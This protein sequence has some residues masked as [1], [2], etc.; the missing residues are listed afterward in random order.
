M[1]KK[2]DVLIIGGGPGG[3]SAALYC[4]RA[5]LSTLVLEMLSAG[6]QMA[7]TPQVDNYPGFDDG[8]DGF[9][10]G[11]KMLAGAE[12]FGAET[13]FAE[14]TKLEWKGAEKI[15]H[16]SDGDFSARTVILA[17]GAGPKKLGLAEEEL[18]T[19]RGVAYCAAC[20]GMQYKGKTVAVAGGGNSAVADALTLSKLCK[21][22]YLV[23]RRDM[24]RADKV[25]L[26]AISAAGNIEIVWNARID[27]F[28]HHEKFEGLSITDTVTKKT[29]SLACDG[30][31][32]AVGRTPNTWLVRGAL[33]M[34]EQGYIAAD[35]T[36]CTSVG[37]VFA[38]GDIRAK[39]LRQIVTAVADGA[40]ASK[41]VQEYLLKGV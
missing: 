33:E 37:G 39:P 21:K 12:R 20:D 4:A 18:L 25:Y 6:G 23:H 15:A 2:Y 19:G 11:E 5:G 30:V 7:T 34:D 3:Y 38:V 14:V 13:R 31:F 10:L 26:D 9:E 24:L 16:T 40:V 1:E 29:Y 28:L 32:V 8:I 27:A 22:V 35:E 41:F 17:M 36:T